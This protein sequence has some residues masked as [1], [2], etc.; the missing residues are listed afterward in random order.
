[1]VGVYVVH[2]LCTARFWL[3]QPHMAVVSIRVFTIPVF[4]YDMRKA[5]EH[6]VPHWCRVLGGP[7]FIFVCL[8]GFRMF[9][10]H[11]FVLQ[12]CLPMFVFG[13][14]ETLG[15]VVLLQVMLFVS[16]AVPSITTKHHHQA[17]PPSITTKN[18]HSSIDMSTIH[19]DK[20]M[21]NLCSFH[22]PTCVGVCV[23][24]GC[25]CVWWVYVCVVGACA[26]LT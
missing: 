5:A 6:H 12:M 9:G 2:M 14:A 24:G 8:F 13:S 21:G 20:S 22:V 1:M 23:C 10:F 19:M 7:I 4:T 11:M 16:S 18:H 17:S 26:L 25:M 3:Q 15:V